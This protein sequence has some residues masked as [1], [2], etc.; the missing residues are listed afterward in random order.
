MDH[1]QLSFCLSSHHSSDPIL[2]ELFH[3]YCYLWVAVVV[4]CLLN[5]ICSVCSHFL[6]F[7]LNHFLLCCKDLHHCYHNQSFSCCPAF[8]GLLLGM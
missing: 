6:S 2:Q 8:V 1:R 4:V 5:L 3:R 7:H